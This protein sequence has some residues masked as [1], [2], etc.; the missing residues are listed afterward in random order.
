MSPLRNDVSTLKA[1]QP[2]RSLPGIVLFIT[3]QFG[4]LRKRDIV[5][6]GNSSFKATKVLWC[7]DCYR[8]KY[9]FISMLQLYVYLSRRPNGWYFSYNNTCSYFLHLFWYDGRVGV[10]VCFVY[11]LTLLQE[12]WKWSSIS[13][14]AVSNAY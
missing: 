10:S 3:S 6:M 8:M 5:R 12:K 4:V 1:M 11:S 9:S 14:G 2:C 13:I 7:M